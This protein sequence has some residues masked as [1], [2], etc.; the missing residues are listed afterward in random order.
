[1]D[2]EPE[3]TPDRPASAAVARQLLAL[4][5][6]A[7]AISANLS[8]SET[9]KHIVV[10]AAEL[11]DAQYAALGVPDESGEYLAEFITTGI[12]LEAEA[13]IGHRPRG[14]GLLGVSLREGQSLRLTNLHEHPRSVGFPPNH[15]PMTSFLGVP[16]EHKGRRLGNLY[17]TDKRSAVEFSATDQE[18]IEQLAA[19]AG[20]AIDNAQLYARVQQLSVVEERQRIGMDLHD[21]VIQSIYAV[22][23]TLEYVMAQL[24]DGEVAQAHDR[25]AG[26]IEGLNATIRDIRT[27]IL[28]LRPRGFQGDNLIIAL[29]RL[30][31]EFKANTLIEVT[32]HGDA[33]ADQSLTSEA[34][35]ALF[36]IAQEALSNAA[37]HSRAS[38]IAV[39]LV[40]EAE[41]VVLSLADNGRGFDPSQVE[42]RLGHGLVNMPDRAHT[43]GGQLSVGPAPGGGTEVRV[44]IPKLRVAS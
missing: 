18:L 29:E 2:S 9:L 20:I 7:L 12:S 32:F 11:V 4:R 44:S 8:L 17:L 3:I 30:L 31:S 25:L 15:P 43:L 37:K 26:A 23:L 36:H 24:A 27:Y 38:R 35:L 1:M 34:R 6:A 19:H 10:A 14:H 39:Q 42:Q 5:Q 33:Q 40:D 28:D 22:G 21:G 41:A 16:I 13:R